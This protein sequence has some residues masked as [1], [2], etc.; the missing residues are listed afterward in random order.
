MGEDPTDRLLRS[1]TRYWDIEVEGIVREVTGRSPASTPGVDLARQYPARQTNRLWL[2]PYVTT[3]LLNLQEVLKSTG[4]SWGVATVLVAIL[5]SRS[6]KLCCQ[7]SMDPGRSWD[8]VRF[9]ICRSAV[10]L[11]TRK[12]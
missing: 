1:M 11:V 4:S 2:L 7:L 3:W 9:R 8:E 5:E 12:G 10:K 6:P